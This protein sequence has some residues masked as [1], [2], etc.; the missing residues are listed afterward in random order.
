MARRSTHADPIIKSAIIDR[1]KNRN[2]MQYV[3]I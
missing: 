2:K 1:Y 3:N